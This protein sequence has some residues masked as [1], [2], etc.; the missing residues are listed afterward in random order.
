MIVWVDCE[1]TGLSEDHGRLL[2]VA[3][4]V[5]DDDLN[6]TGWIS[7]VFW[8]YAMTARFEDIEYDFHD[9]RVMHEQSGLLEDL[10]RRPRVS[11]RDGSETLVAFVKNA[12]LSAVGPKKDDSLLRRD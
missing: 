4:V 2:E 1:T 10:R 9:V 3:I 8:P 11:L 12:A 7:R 5:T 6:E